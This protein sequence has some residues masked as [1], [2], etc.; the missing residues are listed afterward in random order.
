MRPRP[1]D[2]QVVDLNLAARTHGRASS[3]YRSCPLEVVRE[4]T[5]SLR[6]WTPHS[7][8]RGWGRSMPHG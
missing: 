6:Q 5:E 1:E 4:G 8:A 7:T 3:R 2:V